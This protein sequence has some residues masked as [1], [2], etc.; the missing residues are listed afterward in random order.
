MSGFPFGNVRADMFFSPSGSEPPSVAAW[1][2]R[3]SW[4]PTGR[5]APRMK[6]EFLASVSHELRSPLNCILGFTEILIDERPG[7]LNPKQKEYLQD[8]YKSATH[9]LQLIDDILDIAKA[10]MGRMDIKPEPFPPAKAIGDVCAVVQGVA[11]KKRVNVSFDVPPELHSVTLDQRKFKQVCYHLISNAVKFTA[12]GGEVRVTAAPHDGNRFQL[13]V[14][15]TGIG[16]KAEELA[17]LFREREQSEASA[18]TEGAGLALTRRLVERH[19]GSIEVQSEYGHG[20]TFTVTMP[21]HH[22]A[23]NGHG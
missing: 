12:G 7:P 14:K 5:G 1:R 9:L 17:R 3:P 16:I 2:G 10:E 4:E 22:P 13:R 8:V 6:G 15:D 11:C 21:I 23:D 19:G 20:S 18:A